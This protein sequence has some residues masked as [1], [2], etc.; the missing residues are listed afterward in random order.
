MINTFSFR[1]QRTL[2]FLNSELYCYVRL[3]HPPRQDQATA[4]QCPPT[5]PLTLANLLLLICNNDWLT[6][7]CIFLN[8]HHYNWDRGNIK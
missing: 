5:A 6:V 8:P 4:L 3:L 2:Y 1:F 7:I